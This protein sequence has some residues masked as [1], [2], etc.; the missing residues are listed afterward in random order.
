MKLYEYIPNAISS[1]RIFLI[2]LFYYCFEYRFYSSCLLILILALLSD[3]LD[4]FLARKLQVTSEVG[5]VLDPA[6][7]KIFI[8]F[9]LTFL[10]LDYRLQQSYM[11]IVLLRNFVQIMFYPL[12]RL[13]G[14]AFVIKPNFWAKFANSMIF[15]IIACE[16]YYCLHET[17]LEDLWIGRIRWSLFFVSSCFEI[18]FMCYYPSRFYFILEG[19]SKIF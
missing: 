4:G 13:Y 2:P 18:F 8:L 16:L 14:I 3:F 5:A 1:I 12:V 17:L 10:Y 19:K 11:I 15:I 7:D 9:T 6:A